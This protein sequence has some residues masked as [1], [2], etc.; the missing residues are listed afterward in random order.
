MV[1]Y[2][3]KGSVADKNGNAMCDSADGDIATTDAL[4]GQFQLDVD[5]DLAQYKVLV[6]AV[7]RHNRRYGL[8][9]PNR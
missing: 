5:D 9:Q 2:K 6:E 8:P 3:A 4:K 7:A 1:I